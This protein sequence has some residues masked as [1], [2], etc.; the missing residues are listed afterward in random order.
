VETDGKLVRPEPELLTLKSM[1][2]RGCTAYPSCLEC[3]LGECLLDDPRGRQK[4]R[5]ALRN[6]EILKLWKEGKT[7]AELAE[8][9]GV[10]LDTIKRVLK[11]DSAKQD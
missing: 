6:A 9:F 11:V 4:L 1:K 7:P 10:C 3:P 5:T 8:V 2:D